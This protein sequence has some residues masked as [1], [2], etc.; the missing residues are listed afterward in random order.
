M[1]KIRKAAIEEVAAIMDVIEVARGIMHETGNQSQWINGYPST[2]D[3][4]DNIK[5]GN[6]YICINDKEELLGTFCWI[7]GDDPTY[8]YIE[9][10]SWLNDKPYGVIHRLASNQKVKGISAYCINWCAA[11][12]PNI[13]VDTHAD[14]KIM[15]HI[16]ERNG[17]I[18]CGTIYVSN[19]TPRIAYQKETT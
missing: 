13:R 17:F 1:I 4:L 5:K 6:C 12:Y 18:K 7:L 10:G 19:G 14:N 15:Q 3:M 9:N 16:L 2:N 11:Q 8:T